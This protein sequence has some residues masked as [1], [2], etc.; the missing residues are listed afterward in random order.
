MAAEPA[1]CDG[2]VPDGV[3][4]VHRFVH[5]SNTHASAL[6]PN[7]PWPPNI[8]T[9]WFLV[10][11]TTGE[12]KRA[13][14]LVAGLSCVHVLVSKSRNQISSSGPELF[15]PAYMI[16]RWLCAVSYTHLTLPTSDLV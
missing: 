9:R 15:W 14:G 3:S 10:S 16:M 1:R 7:S 6:N 11:Y 13:L 4:C 8:V 2:A 12:K 5:R